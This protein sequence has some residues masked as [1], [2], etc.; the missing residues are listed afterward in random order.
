MKTLICVVMAALGMVGSAVL[1][2]A[3]PADNV[4]VAV[5]A[6]KCIDVFSAKKKV[7][8]NCGRDI[9]VPTG[10]AAEWNTFRTKAPACVV[11]SECQTACEKAGGSLFNAGGKIICRFSSVPSGYWSL[12]SACSRYGMSPYQSWS[13]TGSSSC[14]TATDPQTCS[15]CTTGGHGWSNT[16]RESCTYY[17]SGCGGCPCVVD[18][19]CVPS[20][21]Q[22][23]CSFD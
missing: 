17:T 21:T 20:I 3:N 9:F 12:S 7:K 14:T 8:N 1:V 6:E 19:E 16:P 13:A 10:T 22:A 23:G 5:G 15:P 4:K 18:H 11:L 2:R